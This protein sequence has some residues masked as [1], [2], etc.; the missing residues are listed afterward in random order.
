ML[1]LIRQAMSKDEYNEVFEAVVEIDETYVGG[2]P[3]KSNV[4]TERETDNA[5]NS[6]VS[7]AIAA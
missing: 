1:H 7:L 4:H 5:F 6:I 3:K 2:K